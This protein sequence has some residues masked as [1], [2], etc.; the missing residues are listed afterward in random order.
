MQRFT[1][2]RKS[3]HWSK[4][5]VKKVAMLEAEGRMKQPGQKAYE[6]RTEENTA[7]MV[8]EREAV[9]LNEKFMGRLKGNEEAS[10]WFDGQT[11]GYRRDVEDWIM[12]A[13]REETR[14]RRFVTLLECAEQGLKV[15]HMRKG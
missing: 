11:K 6:L 10:N 5:N 13:K 2:R 3:S 4:I 15:P 12:S 9:G 8:G 7:R 1:P 14:E